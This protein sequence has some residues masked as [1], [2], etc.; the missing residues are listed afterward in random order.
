MCQSVQ[1]IT[2]APNPNP[3]LI[4][5]EGKGSFG[6]FPAT[7]PIRETTG[8]SL[9]LMY[10]E[11]VGWFVG[12]TE[13]WKAGLE[14][15]S[16]QWLSPR[17]SCGILPFPDLFAKSGFPENYGKETGAS[18]NHW[19]QEMWARTSAPEKKGPQKEKT[20]LSEQVVKG[21]VPRRDWGI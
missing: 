9:T 7:V 5:A 15:D 18:F 13:R 3:V 10:S 17:H 1:A 14:N 6:L 8:Y 16:K 19:M 11:D 12:D 20:Q 21:Q 4:R 2:S